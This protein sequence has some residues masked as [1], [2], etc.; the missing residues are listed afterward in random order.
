MVKPLVLKS[1][2]LASVLLSACGVETK[3]KSRDKKEAAKPAAAAQG[4]ANAEPANP[5]KDHDPDLMVEINTETV[6]AC[7][8]TGFV[9]ERR[10]LACSDVIQ[11]AT[12]FTCDRAGI[13]AAFTETGFQIDSVLDAALGKD[14]NADDHGDGFVIDQCGETADGRRLAYLVRKE[15]GG[16]LRVREVETHL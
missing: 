11:I 15:E 6:Q 4:A 16:K 5:D 3:M 1:I 2:V 9:F 8:D 7:I 12:S 14:D 13:R 10:K